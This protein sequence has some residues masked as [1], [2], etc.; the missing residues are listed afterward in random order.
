MVSVFSFGQVETSSDVWMVPFDAEAIWLDVLPALQGIKEP[1]DSV[2]AVSPETV[3]SLFKGF[4]VSSDTVVGAN[5]LDAGTG[6]FEA[7]LPSERSSDKDRSRLSR[8]EDV[9]EECSS[10]CLLRGAS[11]SSM[12][13]GSMKRLDLDNYIHKAV[14]CSRGGYY[15][16]LRQYGMSLTVNR[17]P[18]CW[19][20]LYVSGR[21]ILGSLKIIGTTPTL[22]LTESCSGCQDFHLSRSLYCSWAEGATS[23]TTLYLTVSTAPAARSLGMSCSTPGTSRREMDLLRD[24]DA[25]EPARLRLRLSQVAQASG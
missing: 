18:D 16:C 21:T 4:T 25:H 14:L 8:C 6:S 10:F 12:F 19:I 11:S 23:K 3:S 20:C 24:S 2:K 22:T 5:V 7:V 9:I 1:S 15:R 13:V 17:K